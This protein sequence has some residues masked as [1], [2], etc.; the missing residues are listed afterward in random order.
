MDEKV[1]QLEEQVRELQETVRM[2]E[3]VISGR[4]G[5]LELANQARS[6]IITNTR[7][8]DASSPSTDITRTIS[9]SGGAEDI[10]VLDYPAHFLRIQDKNNQT[11]QVPAYP[12][13]FT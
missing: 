4:T 13:T 9:L 11:F 8:H 3:G 2:M 1:R 6:A 12:I 7:P 10:T 5:S